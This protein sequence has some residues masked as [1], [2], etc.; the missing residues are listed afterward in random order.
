M[1]STLARLL[2]MV[3]LLVALGVPTSAQA[4]IDP[5]TGSLI[6][7]GLVAAV[8]GVA[9]AAGVYWNRIKAFFRRRGKSPNSPDNDGRDAAK[10]AQAK[11]PG[12]DG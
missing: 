4:Y 2:I 10:D 6:L 8:A 9:V 1:T 11:P 3:P 5:G 12:D 7:Q